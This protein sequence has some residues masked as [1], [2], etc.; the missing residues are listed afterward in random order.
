MFRKQEAMQHAT[1][2]N[3]TV[4]GVFVIL[5]VLVKGG[6]GRGHYASIGRQLLEDGRSD[7]CRVSYGLYEN[8]KRHASGD[9]R[10]TSCKHW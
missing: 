9:A 8:V 4:D 5:D 2:A 10:R 1:G 3:D 7:H 6:R